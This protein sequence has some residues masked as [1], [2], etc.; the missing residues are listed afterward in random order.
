MLTNPKA[1]R[2]RSVAS[3]ARRSVRARRGCFLAEGPQVVREALVHRPELVTGLYVDREA[4]AAGGPVGELVEAAE[5]AGITA[6]PVTPAVMAAMCDTQTP[7]GIVAV[8][9]MFDADLTSVLHEDDADVDTDADAEA[10][11]RIVPR[12]PRLL[13]VLAAVRDPGNAGTVIRGA[14]AAGADAV[15]L[16]TDSVDPFNPKCVRATVGSLFHLPIVTGVPIEEVMDRLRGRGL[17][18]L[19]ADGGATRSVEEV[20]LVTP[21]AWVFGNEARGLPEAVRR[22]CDEVARIPLYGKAESLNLAMAATICLYA[23]ASAQ[24]RPYAGHPAPG[25]AP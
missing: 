17:R 16:T 3:L 25:A 13:A 11:A 8:C 23:S 15:L 6:T 4:S 10:D 5:A 18:L 20:D 24:H 21:H 22:R 9:R 2:V 7:Q 14:D 12:P 1:E 19:A